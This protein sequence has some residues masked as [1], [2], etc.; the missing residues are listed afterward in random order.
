MF[1]TYVL[2]I[3]AQPENVSEPTVIYET[4][5]VEVEPEVQMVEQEKYYQSIENSITDKEKDLL[6][7]ILWLE[8][9]NQSVLGQRAVVEVV[10]NRVVDQRFPDNVS[11]VLHQKGQFTSMK[12][13]AKATPTQTQYDVIDLVLQE[14]VPLLPADTV[15]FATSAANG[16]PYERIGSH[17]FCRG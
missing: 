10:F 14:V 6:A 7:K 16:T 9:G 15:Y 1:L 5:F 2:P 12:R 4:V 13:L 3:C 17:Y 8:A 11:D